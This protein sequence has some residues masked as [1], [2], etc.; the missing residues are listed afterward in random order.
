MEKLLTPDDVATLL[1]ISKKSVYKHARDLGGFYLPGVKSL[2]F[3][4][5][6]LHVSL[7]RRIRE[8]ALPVRAG[9]N[10]VLR[11]G[12]P[13][14]EGCTGS[15]S[16]TKERGCQGAKKYKSRHGLN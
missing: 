4:Q 8:M 16:S 15:G 12:I 1:Q 5:E 7:E 9:Q 3:K 11:E 13:D 10:T 14:K 2:R 6:V